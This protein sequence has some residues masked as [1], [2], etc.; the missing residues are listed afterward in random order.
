[1][2]KVWGDF[3]FAQNRPEMGRDHLKHNFSLIGQ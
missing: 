2:R 1:M 3:Y